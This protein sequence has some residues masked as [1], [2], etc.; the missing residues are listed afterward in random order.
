MI[1][2]L[3]IKIY[4]SKISDEFYSFL[5]NEYEYNLESYEA[6][7]QNDNFWNGQDN[8]FVNNSNYEYI[9]NNLIQHAQ[10][11]IGA[12]NLKLDNQWINIQSHDGFLPL[13]AHGGN[14]SYVIYLKVPNFKINHEQLSNKH[15]PYCEG[16][17][18]FCYGEKNSLFY[19]RTT[20]LPEEKMIV[21]FPSEVDH[22]VYPFRERDAKRVSISGNLS[23]R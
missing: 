21:M 5:L 10:K 3:G 14:I 11:Y 22:Y 6:I 9:Q 4:Q 7:Q 23:F 8:Q 2:D 13:H 15:I 1:I 20:I 18:L 16:G 12:T 19:P 17:L